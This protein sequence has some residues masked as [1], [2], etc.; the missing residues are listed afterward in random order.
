MGKNVL[1]NATHFYCSHHVT[2]L[3]CKTSI[4][5]TLGPAEDKRLTSITHEGY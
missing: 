4:P 1:S 3:P 2:W 5:S